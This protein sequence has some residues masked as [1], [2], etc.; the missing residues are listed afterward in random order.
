MWSELSAI[1]QICMEELWE[2]WCASTNPIGAVIVNPSGEVIIRARNHIYDS[3]P[4]PGIVANTPLAHAELNALIQLP[5]SLPERSRY[6]IYTSMEPCPLCMGAIYMSGI[7]TVHVAARDAYSGS[8]DILGKTPYLSKKPIRVFPPEN[9]LLEDAI[10]VFHTV[11]TI[12]RGGVYDFLL[13][14]WRTTNPRGVN[15]G[16]ELAESGLLSDW[17]AEN[18]SVQQVLDALSEML[19]EKTA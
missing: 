11:F 3:T 14:A 6:S 10:A 1:W 15:L 7:K 4:V 5:T 17:T 16:Q 8:L 18:R 9:L 12:R 19:L 13:D 2:A